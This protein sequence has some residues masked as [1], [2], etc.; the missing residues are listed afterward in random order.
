MITSHATLL[1]STIVL[2]TL[3]WACTGDGGPA[4]SARLN[5][6]RGIALDKAGNLYIADASNRVVRKIDTN[7]VITTVAG[8]GTAGTGGD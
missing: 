6:P 7:G 3:T 2:A 8:N 4:L 1:R 5:N